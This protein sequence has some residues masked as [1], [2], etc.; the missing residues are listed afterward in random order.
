MKKLFP[1]LLF[2]TVNVMGQ[3]QKKD[4]QKVVGHEKLSFIYT[5]MNFG[6]MNKVNSPT[7][8]LNA[9]LKVWHYNAELFMIVPTRI[10]AVTPKMFGIKAGYQIGHFKPFIGLVDM[11]VGK[12]TE[13]RFKGTPDEFINGWR[14]GAGIAY[15]S[16]SFPFTI[17][18]EQLGKYIC[19]N[20]GCYVTF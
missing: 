10:L 20:I 17:S 5:G 8:E 19:G 13:T 1:L 16:K 6:Y 9:G 18:I 12:E 15:Y 7:V 3:E 2:I 14:M 11:S 4:Q